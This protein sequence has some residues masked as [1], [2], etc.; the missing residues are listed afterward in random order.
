MLRGMP[1]YRRWRRAGGTYFFTVVT[2]NRA[3]ILCGEAARRALHQAIAS[4][5]R[6]RPFVLEAMVLLPEH[7]HA[8]WTQPEGDDDF[9]WRWG[10]IKA[11]F[12]RDFI[13]GG[14]E[15][16]PQS[17]SRW[18]HR[19]RGVWQ[20]RFWEHVIRDE[21]DLNRH[22]DYIHYNP[23]KHGLVGCPHAWP[24]SSFA[25][26]VLR[27]GYKMNWLCTCEGCRV[28]PPNFGGLAGSEFD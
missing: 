17:V 12:T 2:A 1:E 15:E 22:L 18:R 14:S 6:A 3:P 4:V 8:I 28:R 13:G 10:A 24:H 25:R 5:G 16:E 21:E 19:H 27:G 11:Y 20:R 9:S 23:V 7:L 26:W